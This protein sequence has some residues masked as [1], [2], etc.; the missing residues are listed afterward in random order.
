MELELNTGVPVE[1]T[2]L[3]A[4]NDEVPSCYSDQPDLLAGVWY[5]VVGTGN[6]AALSLCEIGGSYNGFAISIFEGDSCGAL[7]CMATFET[8][9]NCQDGL[10]PNLF[11]WST[12]AGASYYIFVRR[13]VW[14]IVSSNLSAFSHFLGTAILPFVCRFME[15]TLLLAVSVWCRQCQLPHHLPKAEVANSKLVV[16]I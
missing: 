5:T 3:G 16:Y 6:D 9:E 2:I 13:I 8:Y 10:N 12:S 11:S 4:T 14:F 1:G 7:F 15:Y